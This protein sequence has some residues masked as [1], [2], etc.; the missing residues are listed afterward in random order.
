MHESSQDFRPP[1]SCWRRSATRRVPDG[2]PSCVFAA[3]ANQPQMAGEGRFSGLFRART[4][5]N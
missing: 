4:T 3:F 2:S 1:R 5:A